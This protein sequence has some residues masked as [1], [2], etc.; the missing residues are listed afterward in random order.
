MNL[1]KNLYDITNFIPTNTTSPIIG[2]HTNNEHYNHSNIEIKSNSEYFEYSNLKLISIIGVICNIFQP[3][4][5]LAPIK[6]FYK[7]IVE[8]VTKKIPI[9][10]FIF[11]II[12]NL[13]WI[14]VSTKNLDIAILVANIISATFF[15]IFLFGFLIISSGNKLSIIMIKI[16]ATLLLILVFLYYGYTNLNFSLSASI[17]VVMETVC[18]LSILQFIREVFEFEDPSYIDLPI[19]ASIYFVNFWWVIYSIIKSNWILFIPNFLGFVVSTGVLFINYH[20]SIKKGV[21]EIIKP[22]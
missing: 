9:Y 17:A 5:Y 22:L 7:M 19:V 21:K 8:K 14:I 6:C 18:Y 12:Q 3:L 1:E 11:N 20:F 10:Y 15:V 2:F 16:N 13:V 4:I